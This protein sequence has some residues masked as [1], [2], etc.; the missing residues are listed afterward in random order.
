MYRLHV[1]GES[2]PRYVAGC[3]NL[4]GALLAAFG[5]FSLWQMAREEREAAELAE[6]RRTGS[7]SGSMVCV[8]VFDVAPAGDDDNVFAKQKRSGSSRGR[9][10]GAVHPM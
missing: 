10:A 4:T 6:R 8:S 3:L 9:G 7:A 5:A 1:L 2:G